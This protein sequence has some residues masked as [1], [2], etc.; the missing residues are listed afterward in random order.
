MRATDAQRLSTLVAL[1]HPAATEQPGVLPLR[2]GK[3]ILGIEGTTLL[4]QTLA[5]LPNTFTVLRV[6]PIISAKSCWL[7]LKTSACRS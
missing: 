5:Q 1:N 4:D 6:R 3:A 2:I 7:R